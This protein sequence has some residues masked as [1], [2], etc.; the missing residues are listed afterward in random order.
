M[1][2]SSVLS[3]D[4]R[5]EAMSL[6]RELLAAD[7]AVRENPDEVEA[8]KRLRKCEAE[9]WRRFLRVESFLAD[10]V[11]AR[12]LEAR[13]VACNPARSQQRPRERQPARR[14][15]FSRGS[16]PDP[17]CAACYQGLCVRHLSD[18]GLQRLVRGVVQANRAVTSYERR[19]GQNPP[20]PKLRSRLESGS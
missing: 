10:R 7:T 18:V 15:S 14:H 3:V 1:N 12:R 17:A 8:Q 4:P 19:H 2:P 9:R 16:D 5:M 6:A 11:H 20:R 13:R